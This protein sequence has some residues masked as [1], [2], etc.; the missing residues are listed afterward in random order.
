MIADY[1]ALAFANISHRR[2][3][4]LLTVIGIFIGIAAIV[5]LVAT[6]GGLQGTVAQQ[7]ERLG[8][9]KITIMPAGTFGP[10]GI[11][12]K[13][14]T[15]T[16][17]QTISKT[18]GVM[19]AA[20][21]IMTSTGV[22]AGEENKRSTILGY[23]LDDTRKLFEDMGGYAMAAGR[24]LRPNDGK[25]IVIGS[26]V[27]DGLFKHKVRV[28]ESLEINT[29]KYEVIGIFEPTGDRGDDSSIYMPLETLRKD[30][31]DPESVSMIL[32]QTK[33]GLVPATVAKDITE[34]LR[35]KRGEEKGAETFLVSTA[36]Q[37]LATF[38]T[39]FSVIQAIVVGL[40][41]ISLLVGGIG[42]MNTMY[43]AVLERNKEIGI[44]KAIGARNADILSI[45]LTE[46][47]ILG[48]VGGA[49]G[50][51]I[52]FSLG[53]IVEIAA[54]QALNT[55]TFS[56]SFPPYLTV[57]A[58]VFSMVVGALSGTLP[59]IQAAKMKPAQVLR[60]E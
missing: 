45:F 27:A 7:F 43:T 30:F 15:K 13:G 6:A 16:D 46:S 54:R 11:N 32:A 60:Y 49:L 51:A 14:L 35:K 52:G 21:I 29:K 17:L 56:A 41:A 59:A 47:A 9:D 24:K 44:M 33:P 39:I 48:F 57:G 4:S 50:V 40:A 8:K 31:N 10:P 37:L 26:Y 53:K 58:M 23:P 20:G 19:I 28:G 12:T 18:R 1:A 5:A 42:I 34:K 2:T 38:N 3:R 36:E 22:K 55:D 25:K